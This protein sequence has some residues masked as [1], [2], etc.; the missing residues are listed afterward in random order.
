MFISLFSPPFWTVR[1][2]VQETRTKLRA[3]GSATARLALVTL[4]EVMEGD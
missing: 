1:Q 4:E 3:Q 2:P